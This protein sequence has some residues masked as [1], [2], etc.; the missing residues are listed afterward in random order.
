MSDQ[1]DIRH[2]SLSELSTVLDWAAAEGWNPGLFDA[3]TFYGVD[4]EGFLGTFVEDELAAAISLVRFAD[5][6]VFLGLYICR[7]DLRGQ[8]YGWCV[9]QAA[10]AQAGMHTIGLDGVPAQQANYARSGFDFAWENARYLGIGGGHGPAGLIDLAAVPFDDLVE[11]DA[12]ISGVDRRAFLRA[13]L[14]QPEGIGLA[15]LD[16]NGSILGWGR[17]RPCREGWK[18]G[19][20]LAGESD[21]AGRVLDGLLAKVPDEPMALDLPLANE[22]AVALATAREMVPV[23]STA[24]MYRGTPPTVDLA[25]LWGVASFELG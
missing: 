23:F 1:T 25:R 13:W 10:M 4:P 3:E 6:L 21:S 14:A 19:P 20:L 5:S 8:G 18:I 7:P 17:M 15:D 22:D 24:R 2:L 16:T 9:W 11:M 12:E